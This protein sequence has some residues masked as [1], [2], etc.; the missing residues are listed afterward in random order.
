MKR[1]YNS[2]FSL[3]ELSIVILIIGLLIAG[4]I[5]GSKMYNKFKL[6]TARSVTLSSPVAG[7]KDLMLWYETSLESSF[8]TT[9]AV[10]GTTISAWYDN[11]PQKIEKNNATQATSSQRPT[12]YENVLNGIPVVRF[13]GSNDGMSF[14][15]TF[16]ANTNY[17]IFVVEQR[18][19]IGPSGG[20]TFFIGGTNVSEYTNLR[21]GY[22]T[23]STMVFSHGSYNLNYT[24]PSYSAPIPRIHTLWFS[25]TYGKKYWENGG[26]NPD[27]TDTRTQAKHVLDSYTGATIGKLYNC[28]Q[29]YN[30]DIAEIISY[31]R[32]L[33]TEERQSVESY[34][35]KKYAI[36]I[37]W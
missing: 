28:C 19:G 34:L 22:N 33:T 15:G 1:S 36:D 35:S 4:A 6:Q 10:D 27:A 24:V 2:A 13:D 17:T 7:I 18:R 14:D 29:Y 20:T 21:V 5:Q 8:K 12:F 26:N 25:Q 32:D 30:G 31:V 3:I 37:S 23:T 11:N 16:L 9:E